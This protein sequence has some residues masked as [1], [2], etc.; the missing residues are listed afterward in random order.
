MTLLTERH[1]LSLCQVTQ[2]EENDHV[3]CV[4]VFGRLHDHH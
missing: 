4:R 1:L 2:N 3:R